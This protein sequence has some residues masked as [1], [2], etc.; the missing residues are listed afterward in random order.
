MTD[1]ALRRAYQTGISTRTKGRAQCPS[2]ETIRALVAREGA[3]TERLALLDHVMSCAACR[4]EVELLRAVHVASRVRP[5]RRFQALA[6]AASVAVL[7]G[8]GGTAV[9]LKIASSDA[10]ALRGNEG[11][12]ELIRPAAGA[13]VTSPTILAW[14]AVTSARSYTVEVL[15][16]DGKLI[17]S[18]DTPDSTLTISTS[19]PSAISSGAYAWWVRAYLPDGSERHSKVARFELH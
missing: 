12:V 1:E 16:P 6:L 19:G 7:L 17:R 8:I 15:T 14:Q 4:H 9:W 2:P 18:W 10:D 13:Q 11:Q 3:E 5:A